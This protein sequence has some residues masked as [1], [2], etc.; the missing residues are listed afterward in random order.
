MLVNSQPVV[1]QGKAP[2]FAVFPWRKHARRGQFQATDVTSLSVRLGRGVHV[3]FS[4]SN[5]LGPTG[6]SPSLGGRV[7]GQREEQLG[8]GEAG[9]WMEGRG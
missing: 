9:D 4:G 3:W 1:L 6:Q 5:E 2:C 8:E 7:D